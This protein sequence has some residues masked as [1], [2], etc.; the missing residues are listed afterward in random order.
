V[1]ELERLAAYE[2]IRQLASHYAVLMDSRDLDALVELFVDDVRVGRDVRGRAALRESFDGTLRGIGVSI[3]N[4][5]THAIT[6]VDDDHAT[7][8]VYCKGEIQDGDRWIHQ[9]IVYTD[10]YE[11]RDG[12]WLF[13]RRI[14]ELFYGAE[15]PLNPMALPPADWPAHHDGRGTLPERWE[16]WQRFHRE[17]GA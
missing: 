1:D 7:G 13:V 11:R 10:T 17:S 8:V 12:R 6:L 9:A 5:G 3:L 15:A 4:V 14:H 2:A 16:S